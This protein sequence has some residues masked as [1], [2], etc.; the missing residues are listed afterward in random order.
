MGEVTGELDFPRS[1]GARVLRLTPRRAVR[2]L[3]QR[4]WGACVRGRGRLSGPLADATAA[5][6]GPNRAHCPCQTMNKVDSCHGVVRE[7]PQPADRNRN[8]GGA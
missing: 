1:V 4:C 7:W 2:G 8:M 3:P 6:A 5:A